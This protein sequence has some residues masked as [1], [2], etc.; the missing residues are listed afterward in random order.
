MIGVQV[1]FIYLPFYQNLTDEFYTM[2]I[3]NVIIAT[4]SVALLASCGGADNCSCF[5]TGLEMKTE[6]EAA[7]GDEAKIKEITESYV[8]DKEACEKMQKE[9][10]AEMEAMSDEEQ[11]TASE[12]MMKEMEECD[13]YQEMMKK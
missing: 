5:E 10:E 2:K 8:G 7:K 9:Q 1:S 13:A 11:E 6:I 12:E 3:K 4:F